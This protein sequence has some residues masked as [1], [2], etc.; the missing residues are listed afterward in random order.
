MKADLH[1]HT[2]YS[3]G[4]NT[5][6]E[7]IE[8]AVSKKLTHIA[9][10]DHD[11]LVGYDE[12]KE[13]AEKAGLKI[14]R[15]LEISARDYESGKVV[16]VL[17]YNIKDEYP[18][19]RICDPMK[20]ARNDKAYQQVCG[21]N[22]LG[23][24]LDYDRLHHHA[25][26]YIFKQHIFELLYLSDQVES[27]F[28]SINETL[29]R[30]GGELFFPMDYVDVIDAVKAIRE[31]GGYAVIAHPN[32]QN[33]IDTVDRVVKYGLK[34][35]EYNHLSNSEEYKKIILE[36]AKKYKLILTGGSDFHG[37]FDRRKNEVGSHLSDGSGYRIFD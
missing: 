2:R 13:K 25:K 34:G 35:I 11:N 8:M 28:P 16:H 9:I 3:D 29:F 26:G 31:A 4:Y 18:I 23:Y 19:R 6:D 10:T 21:L 24:E 17:G 32:Q 5:V 27:I 22:K 30:R 14:V 36:Y 7:I 20:R 12:K 37:K 15:S 33:N 1:L